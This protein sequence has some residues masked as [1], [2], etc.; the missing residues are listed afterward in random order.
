MDNSNEN[1]N[2][3]EEPLYNIGVV[4]RMTD[5]PAS[6]LRVWERRYDFPSPLRTDGGHRLYSEREIVRLHWIKQQVDSGMQT[7]Q[8]VQ[9]LRHAEE[10]GRFPERLLAA[11]PADKLSLSTSEEK[12]ETPAARDDVGALLRGRLIDVLLDYDTDQADRVLAEALSVQSVEAVIKDIIVPTLSMVG[13][14][15][16]EG[17]ISVSTEHFISHYLRQHLLMWMQTGPP[18][19]DI[20]PVL[21]ACAPGEWHELSLIIFGVLLRRLRWP[22]VNLGQSTPLEDL[23][24][25]IQQI[26][27]SVVVLLAMTEEPAYELAKWPYALPHIVETERPIIAYGGR[28][29]TEHPEWTKRVSGLFLGMTFEEGLEKLDHILRQMMEKS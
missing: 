23:A 11:S 1:K 6:T 28:V 2:V 19:F 8:A 25:F 15:W 7:G 22:V 29:F 3:S 16:S 17:R 27:P 5:I 20:D 24:G 21:L 9:A 13:E 18:P 4:S 26:K 12:A 14:D 10:S